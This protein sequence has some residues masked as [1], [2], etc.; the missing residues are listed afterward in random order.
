MYNLI[1]TITIW[2]NLYMYDNW[3][4]N[5]RNVMLIQLKLPRLY[6]KGNASGTIFSHYIYRFRFFTIWEENV[7]I[8]FEQHYSG[9]TFF[10]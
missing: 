8:L 6:L 3:K 9:Q 4:W 5:V 10:I 7:N 2:L 1:E